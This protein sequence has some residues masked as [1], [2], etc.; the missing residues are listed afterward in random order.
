M[1]VLTLSADLPLGAGLTLTQLLAL[2][3]TPRRG[4]PPGH[5][6]LGPAPARALLTSLAASATR[7]PGGTH[8]YFTLAVP[9]PA[10]GP[11]HL[12]TGRLPGTASDRLRQLHTTFAGTAGPEPAQISNDISVEWCRMSDERPEVTT[13]RDEQRPVSAFRDKSVFIWGCGGIGSWIAEFVT[14]SGAAKVSLCDNDTVTGGLLVRQNYTESDIGDN[15]AEALAARLRAIS[16]STEIRAVC[17]PLPGNLADIATSADVIID[18][19]VST[20]VGQILAALAAE[21]NQHTLLAQ[22][23][24]DTRSGTLGILTVSAP[25]NTDGPAVIES[26]AGKKVLADPALELYQPLWQEPLGGDELTPTRG[27][28]VPTFHGSAA[29][30]AAV[31]ASLLNLLALHLTAPASGTHLIALPHS[32]G[33]GPHHHYIEA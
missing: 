14:R 27:C 10:G 19:T 22:V 5:T 12:L 8:Q 24:T 4:G 11:A 32:P 6:G 1:P 23:A 30:L 26:C 28:S 13:R 20:A 9:H 21:E 17:S 2:L 29:D 15:K 25:G 18:A 31:A 7:N 33:P 16:D 3:D